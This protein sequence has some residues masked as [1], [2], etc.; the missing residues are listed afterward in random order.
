MKYAVIIAAILVFA[1]YPGTGNADNSTMD[2]RSKDSYAV[3]YEFGAH[4][5]RQELGLDPDI[6]LKAVKSGL[7]GEK[8]ML[9]PQEIKESLLELRKKAMVL[10]DKRKRDAAK[11][12]LEEGNKFL[13]E[14]QKKEGV[15]LL[16]SGLQYQ[17]VKEGDG[18]VPGI[19]NMATVNYRGT[20]I[21]GVEFDNSYRLPEAPSIPVSGVIK[22]W[23]EALQLMK[24]GS[25]WNLYVPAK[26]AYGERQFGRI[27]P[28][29]ALV[30]EVELLSTAKDPNYKAQQ[31]SRNTGT[32]ADKIEIAVDDDEENA[33]D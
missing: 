4:L 23:K 26:L 6:I 19:D 22:G 12:N 32:N 1:V 31:V 24:V 2:Q 21:N 33:E 28:N 30:F 20:L 8:S 13:A 10:S 25:K 17:V 3:G 18:P 7:A 9:S 16:P 14:N 29:S 15:K 5:M 11:K 27:P